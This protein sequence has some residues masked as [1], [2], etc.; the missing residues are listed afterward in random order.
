M[1]E[2]FP[3]RL[4]ISICSR[5][6]LSTNVLVSGLK[7]RRVTSLIAPNPVMLPDFIFLSSQKRFR[8]F[9]ISSLVLILI[10]YLLPIC[11]YVYILLVSGILIC[12]A[13]KLSNKIKVYSTL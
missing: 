6:V 4:D 7:K 1:V 11:L 9:T 2:M 13:I 8:A 5:K 3:V 10:I 12:N